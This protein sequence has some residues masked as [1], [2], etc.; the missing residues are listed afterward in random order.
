LRGL[1]HD[2]ARVGIASVILLRLSTARIEL[3]NDV[4]ERAL[5][6]LESDLADGV[7]VTIEDA[8]VRV[9]KLPIG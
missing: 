4:V 5:P 8:R 6:N 9:R 2:V 3:V 7:L 1:G